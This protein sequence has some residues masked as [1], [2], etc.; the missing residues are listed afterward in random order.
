MIWYGVIFGGRPIFTPLAMARL[1][2]SPG[3]GADLGL[4][5]DHVVENPEPGIL[6]VGADTEDVVVGAD[7]P[8]RAIPA[9]HTAAF[10]EPGAGEGVIGI[11]VDEA[12]PVFVTP[13]TEL[14]SGRRS[15][16][17]NWRL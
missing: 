8:Q 17:R 2:P 1:R 7:H 5:P 16:P 10:A 14:S 15:S 12:V 4:A 11:E 3:A 9:Q 13:S 6:Q